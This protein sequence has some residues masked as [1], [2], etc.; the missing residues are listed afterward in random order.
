MA[1]F[2]NKDR[3]RSSKVKRVDDT[4]HSSMGIY[5]KRLMSVDQG[6]EFTKINKYSEGLC[7]GCR[8]HDFVSAGLV[9]MCFVCI[10]KRGSWHDSGLLTFVIEK[11]EVY[12]VFCQDYKMGGANLNARFC[13]SC[14]AKIAKSVAQWQKNGGMYANSFYK[15]LRKKQGADWKALELQNIRSPRR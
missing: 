9:D 8:K 14:N 12:C 5:E 6:N 4:E 1:I 15:Y 13:E 3:L 7:Y 10:G 2:D 11:P